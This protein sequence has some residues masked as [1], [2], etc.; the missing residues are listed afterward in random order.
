M[1]A[2]WLPDDDDCLMTAWWLPDDCLTIDWQLPDNSKMIA[3]IYDKTE[4][5]GCLQLHITSKFTKSLSIIFPIWLKSLTDS[6]FFLKM[7]ENENIFWD[8]ATFIRIRQKQTFCP[9]FAP[10]AY[11]WEVTS[12]EVE[13][14]KEEAT[15][16]N[17]V[18]MLN[19]TFLV[20][21]CLIQN[22]MLIL[23]AGL[24]AVHWYQVF[25]LLRPGRTKITLIMFINIWF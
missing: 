11:C 18:A 17:T 1:T 24:G 22:L 3:W 9:K 2:W 25:F 7:D 4:L 6:D 12:K 13:G 8:L 14:N 15:R 19:F 5:W 20:S 23:S 10:A 21:S 16:H